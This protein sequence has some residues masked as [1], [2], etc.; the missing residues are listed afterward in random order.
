MNNITPAQ[1]I[2]LALAMACLCLDAYAIR[3]I[4]A[5]PF[6]EPAQRWAQATIIVLVPVFGAYLTLYLALQ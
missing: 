5:S 3:K 2:F 6:Y 1:W 4:F